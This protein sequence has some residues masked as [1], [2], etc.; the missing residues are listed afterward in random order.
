M[1]SIKARQKWFDLGTDYKWLGAA[2]TD[3]HEVAVSKHNTWTDVFPVL[4]LS[5]LVEIAKKELT[6][7]C[8]PARQGDFKSSPCWPSSIE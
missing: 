3:K 8:Q 6:P 5:R 7:S 2:F 1:Y 4:P